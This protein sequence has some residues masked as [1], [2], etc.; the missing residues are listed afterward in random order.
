MHE[1]AKNGESDRGQR[2]SL[3]DYQSQWSQDLGEADPTLQAA[4]SNVEIGP[5]LTALSSSRIFIALVAEIAGQPNAGDKSSDMSVACLRATDGRL[6]LLGFTGLD[7]LAAWNPRARPVP[8]SAPA[9]AEAALDEN[10]QA[11][12]LDLAGPYARTVTLQDV[13]TLTGRDQRERAVHLL[14]GLLGEVCEL[15]TFSQ[16]PDGVLQLDVPDS[17]SDRVCKI[18]QTNSV[19]HSF[20]PA[21]IAVHERERLGKQTEY[22]FDGGYLGNI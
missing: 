11:L 6:G 22:R 8:I 7:S 21:G 3:G 10:A 18:L 4:M 15:V 1:H 13:V 9:A 5:L 20:V 12:I 16:L 19:L 2:A 17:V 14:Q